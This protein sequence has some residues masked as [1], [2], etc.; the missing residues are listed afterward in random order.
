MAKRPKANFIVQAA[1]F[2]R[3]LDT[4]FLTA[5]REGVVAGLNKAMEV[6]HQDSSN[7][8]YHWQVGLSGWA[9]A[10]HPSKG[11]LGSAR[12]ITSPPVGVRGDRGRASSAVQSAVIARE[13]EKIKSVSNKNLPTTLIYFNPIAKDVPKY[14][15][16]ANILQ[17]G[18]A[19]RRAA[20]AAFKSEIKSG[21]RVLKRKRR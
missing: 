2:N 11:E 14:G 5:I 6:T 19:A 20:V 7:A 1:E 8:A 15:H 10:T 9:G 21:Q 16:N 12:R 3:A 17:A 13:W 18:E 4:L